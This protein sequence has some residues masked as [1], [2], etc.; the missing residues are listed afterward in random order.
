VTDANVTQALVNYYFGSKKGLFVAV[1]LRRGLEI[2]KEREARLA[3]L[4]SAG[5][6]VSVSDIVRAYLSPAFEMRKTPGGRAFIRLQSRLH[7][8]PMD[9]GYELRRKTYDQSTQL[10]VELL[11]ER[12]PHL[13]R[14][15]IYWRLVQTIGAYLYIISD[16]HR[17]DE[18]SGGTI[19]AG[20]DSDSLEQLVAFATGGF[21]QPDI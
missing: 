17:I 10:F 4:Q 18:L 7:T 21:A 1:F 14:R 16:A 8:E 5:G 9:L 13:S 11:T 20:D 15:T 12:L 3:Q 6:N 19:A 2:A